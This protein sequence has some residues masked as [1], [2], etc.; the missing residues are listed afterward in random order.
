VSRVRLYVGKSVK[1]GRLTVFRSDVA[2]TEETHGDRFRYA[3][4]PFRTVRAARIMAE[5]DDPFGFCR[6]TGQ[7]QRHFLTSIAK[8]I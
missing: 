2:P 7:G 1:T 6:K 5:F 8:D 4:G 3:I